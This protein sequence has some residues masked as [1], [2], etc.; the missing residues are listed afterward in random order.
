MYLTKTSGNL[1]PR[2]EQPQSNLQISTVRSFEGGLNV[3]DTDLNMSP[4]F[5]KE[6]DNFERGTDGSQALRPG[7]VMVTNQ[8]ADISDIINHVYFAGFVWSVQASG[9]I[10]TTDGAGNVTVK[11]RFPGDVVPWPGGITFVDFTI[12]NSDLIITNGRD[13]PLIV[14]GRL[15][16]PDG[17][18]NPNYLVVQYLADLASLSTVNIPKGKFVIAHGQYVIFA[19]VADKPSTVFISAKDTSGTYYGE[20]DPA[21]AVNVDLGPRV[22]IGSAT[23][24]G[25]VAYRDKLI[26]TFERGVLPL[27]L[28]VYTG[29]TPPK[30]EPTDDGFVEEFGC[31]AHRSL[32]SV[33]D[34]TFFNDNVGVN[35][36]NRV[37]VFNTLRPVRISHLI[38]PLITDMIQP[39]TQ[40]QIE[41]RVFAVYDL[42]HFRY[43]L[44]IPRYEAGVLV[45]TVC[46][47]YT[48]IPTLKIQTWARL[49]G[50]TWQSA[51]RTALQNII[52][53][54][55]NKLYAYDFDAEVG[56]DRRG[57][58]AV[59]SGRGEKIKFTWEL[60]WADFKHRMDIK[61]IKYIA[62]DSEGE[63]PFIVEAY[64]DN[65]VFYRGERV[66]MLSMQFTGGDAGGY[67]NSPYGDSPYG[68]GR[69]TRDE[70]TY[71]YNTK[72]KLLKLR[73][74]G[75]T[76]K[77]LRIVSIS[78]AYL[79]G[80]IRR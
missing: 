11:H 80:G 56:T 19:G 16:R 1:N 34:D 29:S 52:F 51:C 23:I 71:G 12:F 59:N 10:T 28:G 27:N 6:L 70:R 69:R 37:N 2:G 25:M 61:Y 30:H 43:M 39:L 68:G 66:P 32:V 9:N 75:E 18:V 49:K 48:N 54:R 4:K 40:A 55:G 65:I 77:R 74:H 41:Q 33:G 64:V 57:D 63:A 20:T 31:I 5:A 47:S 60:P 36:I 42:R 21:D 50:W 58:P 46:F 13:T 14:Q 35:S 73:I 79:R 15:T 26:V 62:F 45:E 44:F 38:D 7:T 22:S 17:S 78:I 67:G 53:S 76:D 8:I 24:T 72:F 3:T